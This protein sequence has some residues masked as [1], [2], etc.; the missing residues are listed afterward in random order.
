MRRVISIL[1]IFMVLSVFSSSMLQTTQAATYPDRPINLVMPGTPG[2]IIDI[3][4]RILA[5]ELGK[6]LGVKMVPMNK[7][8]G[9]F[10]LGTDF[11]VRSKPDG[12][13]LAY[14]NSPGLVNARIAQPEIVPY[15]PAKD[16]EPLGLHL[17]FPMGLAVQASS[18]WKTF[19]ELIAYAKKN[20]GKLRVSTSGKYPAGFF[21]MKIIESLAGIK[22][23]QVPYKGGKA[24]VTALLGGHVE[25]CM[26]AGL[27]F[28]PHVKA[29]KLRILMAT[30]KMKDFPD[31]PTHQECG[32]NVDIPSPW[33]A[34][35]APKG[36][37]EDVKKTLV[38]AIKK[39]INEPKSKAK[40]EKLGFLVEYGTPED[41]R[42]IIQEHYK[43]LS[44]IMKQAK[45]AE[46]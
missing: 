6:I 31:V 40:I 34:F 10:T 28:T 32:Y 44:E 41:L 22:F 23:T 8:G 35:C 25:V 17:F 42:N 38:P 20:P 43:K 1:T 24:V 27:K 29:G 12:Y 16:L 5:E 39:A 18:P 11:V 30:K 14:T 4:G 21:V 13:T 33:F 3:T 7:P 45:A 46:K 36:I 19:D 15:D 37:P 9:T 26:D 2:S